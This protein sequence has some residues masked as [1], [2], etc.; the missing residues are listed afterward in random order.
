MV[1]MVMS[2]GRM[3][4]LLFIVNHLNYWQLVRLLD[5]YQVGALVYLMN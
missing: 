2:H 4:I 1:G 5:Y 3:K